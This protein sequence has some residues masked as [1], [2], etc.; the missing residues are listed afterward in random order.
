MVHRGTIKLKREH[1]IMRTTVIALAFLCVAVMI[2]IGSTK[3]VRDNSS[4]AQNPLSSATAEPQDPKGTID[5]AKTPDLI[6][7][8]VAYSLFFNFVAARVTKDEKNSL[9]SYMRQHNLDAISVDAL[10]GAGN[11]VQRASK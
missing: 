6:P 5:G 7:D 3:A 1:Q 8:E 4:T 10:I 9:R 11:D 2:E